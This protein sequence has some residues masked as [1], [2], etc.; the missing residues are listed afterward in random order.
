MGRK[1]F[2]EGAKGRIILQD[3]KSR[4]TFICENLEAANEVYEGYDRPND[5]VQVDKLGGL[6]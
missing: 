6:D 2:K 3:I 5:L 4:K 1:K